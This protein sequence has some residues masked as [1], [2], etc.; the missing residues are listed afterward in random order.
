MSHCDP[1]FGSGASGPGVARG[2]RRQPQTGWD[3]HGHDI[4]IT[5]SYI[6]WNIMVISWNIM[7]ISWNIMVISWNIMVISWLYNMEYSHGFC[8]FSG[9]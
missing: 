7:V 4:T 6:T 1:H 2:W 5:I 9:I 8:F 3:S